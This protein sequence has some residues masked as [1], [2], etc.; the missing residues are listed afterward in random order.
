[1]HGQQ[2]HH[3]TYKSGMQ[4]IAGGNVVRDMLT[5]EEEDDEDFSGSED[6]DD[7]DDDDDDEE[8]DSDEE[9]AL[10]AALQ[11]RTVTINGADGLLNAEEEGKRGRALEWLLGSCIQANGLCGVE[12]IQ[13]LQ[14]DAHLAEGSCWS[15]LSCE[16]SGDLHHPQASC[17]DT[18][19][20]SSMPRPGQQ[21]YCQVLCARD[22]HLGCPASSLYLRRPAGEARG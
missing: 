2:R 18:A 14:C 21:Q 3:L 5:D 13:T 19:L 1:M 8:I 7:E 22:A 16:S 9:A 20:A 6:D 11:A 4:V 15:M 12:M 17:N 10:R